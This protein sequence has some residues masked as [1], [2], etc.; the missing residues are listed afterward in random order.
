[1]RGTLTILVVVAA[2]AAGLWFWLAPAVNRPGISEPAGGATPAAGHSQTAG[3]GTASPADVAR[4]T[5][6]GASEST[7]QT[8]AAESAD[9]AAAG[10]PADVART[11]ES[12]TSE[13]TR[14]TAAAGEVVLSPVPES[15]IEQAP[16][17]APATDEPR[18]K[19]PLVAVERMVEQIETAIRER[20]APES[21]ADT[22]T[23]PR[24]R[25][26]HGDAA[27]VD[28]EGNE[29]ARRV[30]AGAAPPTRVAPAAVAGTPTPNVPAQT[31][32][33]DAAPDE[34]PEAEA[35]QYV[36]TLTA[37]AP[38]TIPID[39]AAHFTT[40]E[41]VLSLVP[42]DT[43]KNASGDEPAEDEALRPET[44]VTVVREVE[45]VETAVPER[46]IDESGGDLDTKLR[47]VVEYEDAAD[48]PERNVAV[49]GGAEG[50]EGGQ[51]LA[52]QD[53]ATETAVA[54]DAV[55]EVTV[56]EI[57]ERI[58]SEPG[59]PISIVRTVRYFEI[60]TLKEWLDTEQDTD[61]SL[62]VAT[63]PH[64]IGA[65][66]LAELLQRQ[67]AGNPRTIFY[68]HTVQPTD[69]QGIWGI[70]HSSLI[71][72]FARGVAVD[73]GEAVETYKVRIPSDADERLHDQSSSFLGKLIDRKTKE[74]F[75][76][77][78]RENRMGRNPDHVHPG[79]E[80]VIINFE[81]EEL[82]SIYRYFASG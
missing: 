13:S 60:M 66:T 59:K 22:G 65:V 30:D 39:N 29:A 28:G 43:I 41:Q 70:V 78:Y 69:T 63:R 16:I 4:T 46:L 23:K 32:D 55:E 11:T 7:R 19:D 49:P 35:K 17:A 24:A 9:D 38:K 61:V 33:S 74:S 77:N 73:R 18:R 52:A 82:V 40:R 72:N 62:N 20:L 1:M 3:S 2:I 57:L 44:P 34:A 71:D 56:R 37:A 75:V 47:V 27:E 54:R 67:K 42:E 80:I 68:L 48:D 15:V 31:M 25:T 45:Q 36:G 76:Y 5:E 58:R 14:Q 81:P 21:G 6:S 51:D 79:Q 12:G 53:G 64:R 26:A 10:S 8:A 50:A